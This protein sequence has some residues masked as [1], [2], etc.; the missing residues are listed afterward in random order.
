ML[1]QGGL[2][3]RGMRE[4]GREREGIQAM[5]RGDGKE[6]GEHP[7]GRPCSLQCTRGTRGW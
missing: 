3:A 5:V 7:T 4:K 1:M 2:F 6:C